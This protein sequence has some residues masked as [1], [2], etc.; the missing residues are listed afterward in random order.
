MLFLPSFYCIE[1]DPKLRDDRSLMSCFI[2]I[3]CFNGKN[4]I[5]IVDFLNTDHDKVILLID[6]N[7]YGFSRKE[8]VNFINPEYNQ[9]AGYFEL[10]VKI[11]TDCVI[12]SK[13]VNEILNTRRSFFLLEEEEEFDLEDYCGYYKHYNIYSVKPF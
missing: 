11:T 1:D 9:L 2:G 7:I 10:Y 8:I 4:S 12:S 5:P 13:N 3:N 6:Y